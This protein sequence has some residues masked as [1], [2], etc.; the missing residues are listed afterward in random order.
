MG[1]VV[2]MVDVGEES[3]PIS[4]FM[5]SPII[6]TYSKFYDFKIY[7]QEH[8]TD[9]LDPSIRQKTEAEYQQLKKVRKRKNR[10][11]I[12]QLEKKIT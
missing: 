12:Y 8:I 3:K 7:V 6:N 1:V 4:Q 2:P 9:K 5:R 11:T 10:F